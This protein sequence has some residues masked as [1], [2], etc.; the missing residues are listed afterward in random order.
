MPETGSAEAVVELR[1]VKFNYVIF[2]GESSVENLAIVI[3]P[4]TLPVFLGAARVLCTNDSA[5]EVA[6]AHGLQVH[7]QPVETKVGALV[8]TLREDCLQQEFA[9]E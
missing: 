6:Q 5:R 7:L 8:Q 4:D 9:W 3:E 2:N 1:S